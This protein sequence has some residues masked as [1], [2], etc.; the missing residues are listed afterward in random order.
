[1]RAIILAAAIAVMAAN[2]T[3]AVAAGSGSDMSVN[4]GDVKRYVER[5]QYGR[6]IDK[7][8]DYLSS[9]PRSADAYNYIGY[10]ERK[11]GNFEKAAKAY[12]RALAIDKNHVGAHEYYGELQ[13]TLGNIPK[14]ETHLAA[15][16][17]ICGTCAEQQDL[18]GK[19]A[20]AKAG[21]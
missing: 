20:K 18:A 1:M 5:E 4:I 15:L 8:Q 9:N 2:P 19:V 21:G 16:T 7:A 6:A 11:L 10:S 12:D 14:A 3:I 13:L 17:Q